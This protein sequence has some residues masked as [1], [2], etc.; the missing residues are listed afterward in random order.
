M[1]KRV[2]SL[3]EPVSVSLRHGNTAFFEEMSQLWWDVG[4]TVS[5]W[6]ARDLNL[7]STAR[8]KNALP[9]DQLAGIFR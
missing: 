5:I 2:T 1:P 6:P 9:H 3:A 8:E 7:W 4:T